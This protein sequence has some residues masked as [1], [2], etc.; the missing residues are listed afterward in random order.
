MSDKI[1]PLLEGLPRLP[2]GHAWVTVPT[3]SGKAYEIHI[4]RPG[5]NGGH[6]RTGYGNIVRDINFPTYIKQD[7]YMDRPYEYLDGTPLYALNAESIIATAEYVFNKF[8]GT[9]GKERAE[10]MYL[11]IF[12]NDGESID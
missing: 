2:E 5:P 3:R 12:T 1:L 7:T 10:E 11:G 8:T 4:V 6:V 9:T